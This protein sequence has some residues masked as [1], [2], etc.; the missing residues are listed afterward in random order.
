TDV[1]GRIQ[2]F[3]IVGERGALT[4][5]GVAC[6][7]LIGYDRLR[8]TRFTVARGQDGFVFTGSGWGHGHGMCQCGA[9]A[10]AAST[11]RKPCEEILSH[12]YPGAS[13]HHL[14]AP[15]VDRR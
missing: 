11:Y 5:K 8:S 12:Y 15:V 2:K 7:S 1:S 14:E 6:R 4:I 3:A 10:M 9:A 13:I